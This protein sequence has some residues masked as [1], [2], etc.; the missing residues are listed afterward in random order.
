MADGDRNPAT[1]TLCLP[2]SPL[3]PRPLRE[4]GL[5]PPTQ[6]GGAHLLREQTPDK[7]VAAGA[8]HL[9]LQELPPV[10]VAKDVG[11]G[12]RPQHGWDGPR[13][14]FLVQQRPALEVAGGL[15][16]SRAALST[17]SG[18]RAAFSGASSWRTFQR[19]KRSRTSPPP[20]SASS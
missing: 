14:F 5:P 10:V 9:G 4:G 2:R 1:G 13:R 12:E 20:G 16:P 8:A 7:V 17:N 15:L 3:A 11:L 6:I 18:S 19:R